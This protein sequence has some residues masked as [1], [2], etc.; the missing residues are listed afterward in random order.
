[1]RGYI[2]INESGQ[3]ESA[4][5]AQ[6]GWAMDTVR[7]LVLEGRYWSRAIRRAA[8]Q[9]IGTR[10]RLRDH[11][12]RRLPARSARVVLPGA[13]PGTQSRLIC[14]MSPLMTFFMREL[15]DAASRSVTHSLRFIS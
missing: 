10:Q 9:A 8:S 12:A 5:I 3:A 4:I 6:Q 7:D 15:R 13:S 2:Y 11:P 1:M 14:G